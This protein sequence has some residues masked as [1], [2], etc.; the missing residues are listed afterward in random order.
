[1][2]QTKLIA[3]VCAILVFA[4]VASACSSNGS[5]TQTPTNAPEQTK[6]NVSGQATDAPAAPVKIK[7]VVSDHSVQA[8]GADD[9]RI[10]YLEEKTNTD[11]DIEFLAH[12][13]YLDQLKLQFA[14]GEFPDVYQSWSG[15]ELDLIEGG[16]ILALN[17]LIDQYGPN[18]K[19]NIPQAA[20]DAVT[21]KGEILAIPQ[22]ALT[23]SGQVMFIRKDWLDKLNLQVPTTSDELLEVLRAFR[24]GDPNGNGEP[25]EIPFSMRENISWGDNIFGMWGVG[26]AWTEYYHN[27]EVILGNIH[28]NILKPLEYINALWNEKLIDSEFLT[29]DRVRWESKI[30]AGFV[31]VWGHAPALVTQW[32]TDLRASIA[33]QNPEVIVIPTPRGTG[34]DGPLGTRWSPINKTFIVTK[35]AENPEAIIRYFDWLMSE[36]GQ[37]FAELGIEGDTFFTATSDGRITFDAK[38]AEG[39]RWLDT[40]VRVHGYNPEMT[41]IKLGDDEMFAYLDEAYTIA[42]TEGF[43]NEAVGMPPIAD[44]R[45]M[46]TMF[47][48]AA[49]KVL[50]G[51]AP[52]SD[53]EKFMADW[54]AQ[55]GDDLIKERTAWYNENRK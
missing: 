1:M 17:D 40:V 34:Y 8:P 6:D 27:D 11:L 49:A 44:E 46:T 43:V 16:K 39:I 4:L 48:E 55:G 13:T 15:P 38:K 45:N 24:D 54:R 23:Q 47:R 53:Y 35:D 51:H 36:E 3:I 10:K 14:S 22:P 32:N 25:D 26:T 9:P 28:P 12:G 20:W 7:M 19:A 29:N 31:G 2:R 33:D 37:I 50:I 52:L 42:N 41:R 21:V 18:L 30:R 5:N